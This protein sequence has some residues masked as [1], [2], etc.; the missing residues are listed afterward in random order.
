MSDSLVR[1]RQLVAQHPGHELARFSLGKALYDRGQWVE[2]RE[3]LA[4][5]LA[6]KPDWMAVQILV[7]KCDLAAGDREAARRAFE[8]ARDLAVAQ[9]HEGPL[10]EM[11]QLLSELN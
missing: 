9:H 8:R 4:A 3:H 6:R 11:E 2:A 1:Q 7:G 5:A 10:A